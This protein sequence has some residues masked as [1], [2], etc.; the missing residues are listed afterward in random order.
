MADAIRRAEAKE[1]LV[2]CSVYLGNVKTIGL[3]GDS[4]LTFTKLINQGFD[5][6]LIPRPH[7]D[8]YVVYNHDQV[9]IL[10]IKE[11]AS[12]RILPLR[13]RRSRSVDD[14][15]NR[16]RESLVLLDCLF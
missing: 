10:E 1:V 14:V 5:S 13:R 11:I 6:V 4:S 7:G 15:A 3:N 9:L 2:T 16:Q 8:E 12:N